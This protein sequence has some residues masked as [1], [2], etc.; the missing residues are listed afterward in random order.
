[1]STVRYLPHRPAHEIAKG[2][3]AVLTWWIKCNS[4]SKALGK[5]W[6]TILTSIRA[7]VNHSGFLWPS[8]QFWRIHKAH[9]GKKWNEWGSG[10]QAPYRQTAHFLSASPSTQHSIPSSSLTHNTVSSKHL[11]HACWV[12][13]HWQMKMKHT[14]TI[15]LN[16]THHLLK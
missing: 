14:Y 12:E 8:V 16:Y 11:M 1:M 10:L 2:N 4:V 13:G 15:L 7:L 5:L 9:S 3:E 6:S